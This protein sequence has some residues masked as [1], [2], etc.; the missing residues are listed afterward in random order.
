MNFILI[1]V[2]DGLAITAWCKYIEYRN[3]RYDM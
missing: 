2:V 3:K 1:M